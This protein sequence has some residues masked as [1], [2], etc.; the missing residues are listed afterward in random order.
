MCDCGSRILLLGP[1]LVASEL[2]TRNETLGNSVP[3]SSSATQPAFELQG[4]EA[5]A[6]YAGPALPGPVRLGLRCFQAR[7]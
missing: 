1:G 5:V 7:S 3:V 6:L 4:A 2:R